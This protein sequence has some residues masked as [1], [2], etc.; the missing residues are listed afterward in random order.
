M[1]IHEISIGRP[2]NAFWISADLGKSNG[3]PKNIFKTS[4]GLNRL[5]YLGG[6]KLRRFRQPFSVISAR[7]SLFD[8]V[9]SKNLKA[10]L[11]LKKIKSQTRGIRSLSK[12]LKNNVIIQNIISLL[13]LIIL[14]YQ[15]GSLIRVCLFTLER[16]LKFQRNFVAKHTNNTI[17]SF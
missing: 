16:S 8:S 10:D 7:F 17:A 13:S 2:K 12:S 3:C 14:F 1:Q 5:Y 4:S 9:K 6:Y 15:K 11:I